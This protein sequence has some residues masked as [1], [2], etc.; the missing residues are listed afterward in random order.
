MNY[1]ITGLHVEEMFLMKG[2][3]KDHVGP[4][5]IIFLLLDKG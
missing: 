1:I 3:R 5:Q 4:C 2:L